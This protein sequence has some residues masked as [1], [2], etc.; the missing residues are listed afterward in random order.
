MGCS[1]PTVW[2]ATLLRP[3]K[4]I[5]STVAPVMRIRRAIVEFHSGSAISIR[6]S[7]ICETSPAGNIASIPPPRNQAIACFKASP[8]Q[9]RG[10]AL[11][12]RIDED[13]MLLQFGNAR[14]QNVRHDLHIRT[15]PFEQRSLDR[16]IEHAKRVIGYHHYRPGDGNA[17]EI[18][19]AD[20]ILH[21]HFLQHVFQ[22]RAVRRL[23]R[24]AIKFADA[25]DG[26]QTLPQILL[27]KQ[28]GHLGRR[29]RNARCRAQARNWHTSVIAQPLCR[30][31]N[32]KLK[33]CNSVITK[34]TPWFGRSRV[35][36][37]R[38][39]HQNGCK[40][41]TKIPLETNYH[42][43]TPARLPD[44]HP[45]KLPKTPCTDTVE[46]ICFAYFG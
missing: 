42:L 9:C 11:S 40:L 30:E 22:Q 19:V 29:T 21:S 10:A 8:V 24:P 34:V 43:P 2:N 41:L 20:A 1:S 31:M 12:E 35:K 33:E 18:R 15:D 46:R 28:I 5:G 3:S 25:M 38:F 17:F 36:G 13:A 6:R 26:L 32:G 23:L 39:L 14:Q 45:C 7:R 27:R 37:A 44:N 4:N 16:A